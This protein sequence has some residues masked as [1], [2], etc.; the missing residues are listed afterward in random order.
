MAINTQRRRMSALR[1]YLTPYPLADGNFT[2]ADRREVRW[3]Y[4]GIA[5]E[6]TQTVD[7]VNYTATVT[8]ADDYMAV[9]TD[10]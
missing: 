4:R 7:I 2:A 9:V 5:S 8:G 1:S 10:V 6:Q 3:I